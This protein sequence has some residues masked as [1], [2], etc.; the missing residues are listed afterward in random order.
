M[1]VA[2]L[3]ATTLH[4]KHR[5]FSEILKDSELATRTRTRNR[6]NLIILIIA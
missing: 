5:A 3:F 1:A 6:T 4:A 2:I